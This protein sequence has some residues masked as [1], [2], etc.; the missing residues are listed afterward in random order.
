MI[1]GLERP[2]SGSI[3]MEGRAVVDRGV[4]L[5]PEARGIGLVFQEGALFPH[6]NVERNVAYG[7]HRAPRHQRRDKASQLLALVD[8]SHKRHCFPH[9]LS[10]G[11]RQRV[12]LARALAP[13]PRLILLD[14]PFSNL[15]PSLRASLRGEI[16]DI[17]RSV[18]TTAILVTH[19]VKDALMIA[20]RLAV[21][22][23]GQLLQSG[24]C[25]EV[26]HHPI[27]LYCAQLF[28]P[29]NAVP[30]LWQERAKLKERPWLRPEE[31]RLHRHAVPDGLEVTVDARQ[32]QGETLCLVTR[33][34]GKPNAAPLLVEAKL[35]EA[36]DIGA[37]GWLTL[38]TDED[39]P[40]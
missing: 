20:D 29:T 19:D 23:E 10:G 17:V 33:E 6:L 8:L 18:G 26:Y 3:T 28:G 35:N 21:L 4:F 30:E 34:S 31:L 14:E 12:A 27:N 24:P 40:R 15:D 36:P 16:Q 5:K 11:E 7:L 2:T 9:E 25:A 37:R 22:Q 1:A 13:D 38:H 39:A 32:F